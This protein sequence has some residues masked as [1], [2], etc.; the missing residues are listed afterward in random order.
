[1][2]PCGDYAFKSLIRNVKEGY[3][4]PDLQKGYFRT[5]YYVIYLKDD[6]ILHPFSKSEQKTGIIMKVPKGCIAM[7]QTAY[8]PNACSVE[9]KYYDPSHGE[10][11]LTVMCQNSTAERV[12]VYGSYQVAHLFLYQLRKDK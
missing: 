7:I 1:M 12:H 2:E 6:I 11:E 3:L 8:K 5:P 4:S 9:E 10:F